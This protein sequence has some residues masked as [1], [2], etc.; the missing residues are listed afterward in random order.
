LLRPSYTT[1]GDTTIMPPS[2][3]LHN[4]YGTR[5]F[6]ERLLRVLHG[7]DQFGD[8][9]GALGDNQAELGEMAK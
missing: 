4:Q 3:P 9:R 6:R 1:A 2:W 5:R 7:R 8:M